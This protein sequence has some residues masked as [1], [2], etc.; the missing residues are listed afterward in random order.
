MERSE[1]PAE[2]EW[3]CRAK[4]GENGKL[5]TERLWGMGVLIFDRAKVR[6]FFARMITL[7][8]GSVLG[9][10]ME[11]LYIFCL[12]N[13]EIRTNFPPT[14]QGLCR[15]FFLRL[16]PTPIYLFHTRNR[17]PFEGATP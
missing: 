1:V 13:W 9:C 17:V 3:R 8:M 15:M 16:S 12:V 10:I 5:K 2:P 6:F 4:G 11:L 7:A 14:F